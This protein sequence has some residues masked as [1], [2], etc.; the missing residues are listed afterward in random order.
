MTPIDFF[1]SAVLRAPN[2]EAAIV[3]AANGDV[4][5]RASYQE[6]A[7][8]VA[9]AAV[10]FQNFSRVNRPRVVLI[11]HNSMSMLVSILAT[12]L[13]RG[14]LVPLT[15]NNP[16]A[17]L[18]EQ[19]Q[20]AKPDLIIVDAFAEH[21]AQKQ[22][23]PVIHAGDG[24]VGSSSFEALLASFAGQAPEIQEAGGEDIIALKFTG[25]SSGRPKAVLQSVRCL[26]TM[27]SS[28]LQV[29]ELSTGDRFLLSPPMTHGAG[30]FVV[31]VLA[32][33]GCLVVMDGAKA[34]QLLDAMSAH[35]V[36]GIWVPPTLLYQMLDAQVHQPRAVPRLRNLLYGGAGATMERLLQARAL[37]GPVIGVTYG[38]TE[39]PV[40]I[41]GMLGKE[42]EDDA[43]LGS[44]GRSGPLTRLAVMGQAGVL[45]RPNELGEV[46]ARGDLLM[47]GYLDMPD[48][49]NKVMTNGW[50]KTGDVG[51]LDE[52]G[53]LYIKGR[54][55]DVIISGGFNVYPSDVEDALAKHE[56]VAE[57]VVFGIPDAHWG[58]RVEAAVELKKG[59][60]L[61]PD[62]L[63]NHVR[64][65]L[66]PVRTPK[67]V[68]VVEQL[69]RNSLG[70]VQ[71]RQLRD[72]LIQQF[73][74]SGSA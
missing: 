41:A 50:L 22:S 9:A 14:V 66:G 39:A 40:I 30:A 54:S 16:E 59:R 1:H 5:A 45:C 35:D 47:S 11:C 21:L 31:P 20:V 49:T 24:S 36:T 34:E 72:E 8:N 44:T 18:R 56:D 64:D 26:N 12:Y 43:N 10:G 25:G 37:F 70:K 53:F 51:Y 52:R 67:A 3:V 65:L 42:S 23:V 62:V 60:S 48:E 61:T 74:R 4:V 57:S 68:H 15:P 55:K 63:R 32:S 46:V 13:C 2:A 28:L 69:P 38:L 33:G 58:E 29:Y 7:K 19:I 71:K 27:I 73:G 6:L 17:E